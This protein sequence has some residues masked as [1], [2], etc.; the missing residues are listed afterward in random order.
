MVLS[1]E[2]DILSELS[3]FALEL[4]HYEAYRVTLI[5]KGL[6]K[7][8]KTEMMSLR[9]G[10]VRESGKFSPLVTELTGKEKRNRIGLIA[11]AVVL[12]A[13]GIIMLLIL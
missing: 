10:L 1:E 3:N 2:Q 6:T 7:Q 12:L 13:A 11:A 5:Q 4:K 8:Q 9:E